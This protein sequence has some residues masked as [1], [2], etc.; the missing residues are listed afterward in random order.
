MTGFMWLVAVT[1]AIGGFLYGYDTGI[2]SGALL[3]ISAEYQLSHAMQ[4]I[5]AAAILLGATIGGLCTGAVSDRFGRRRTI[6]AIAAVFTL[7]RRRRA[8]S[9]ILRSWRSPASR[10]ASPSGRRRNRSRP[11]WRSS[12]PRRNGTG[13]WWRSASRSA[14]AS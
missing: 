9:R 2:I 5:V 12:P 11:T 8:W 10:S 13:S 7:G 4:E 1:A 14:S 6:I 3:S